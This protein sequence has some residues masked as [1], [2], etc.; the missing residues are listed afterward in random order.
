MK[1]IIKGEYIVAE[2]ITGAKAVQVVLGAPDFT[3]SMRLF[4]EKEQVEGLSKGDRVKVEIMFKLEV[5]RIEENGKAVFLEVIKNKS[6]KFI[7][8]A[9]NESA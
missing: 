3:G 9:N 7:E 1:N 5:K 4:A 6:L 8:K 2:I